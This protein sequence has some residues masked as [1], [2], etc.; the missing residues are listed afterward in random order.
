MH[1]DGA[2]RESR[3]TGG[4][5]G[6]KEDEPTEKV[7]EEAEEEGKKA[8]AMPTPTTPTKKER[9]EHEIT[10]I[11]YRSWCEHCVRGRGRH[12][13]HRARE[14]EAKEEEASRVTK[15]YMDFYYNGFHK[16][17]N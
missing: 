17:D 3:S 14:P 9:E 16:E 13:G 5:R 11:P 6:S 10:H 12:K 2:E 15:I 8:K 4:S 7:D 1:R